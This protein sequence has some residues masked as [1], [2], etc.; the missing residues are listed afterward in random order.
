MPRPFSRVRPTR[1]RPGLDAEADVIRLPG[2]SVRLVQPTTPR[3]D[4]I[5]LDL[6]R[7]RRRLAPGPVASTDRGASLVEYAL[8]VAHRRRVHLASRS[9]AAASIESPRWA[10]RSAR[11]ARSNAA[12]AA[13]RRHPVPRATIAAA[14]HAG[15][16]P[17]TTAGL[18]RHGDVP[19]TSSASRAPLVL[20]QRWLR[21]ARPEHDVDVPVVEHLLQR[22]SAAAPGSR[23]RRRPGTCRS[24]RR[25]TTARPSPMHAARGSCPTCRARDPAVS[26]RAGRCSSSHAT[27]RRDRSRGRT[28]GCDEARR[29]RATAATTTRPPPATTVPGPRRLSPVERAEPVGSPS[30][31]RGPSRCDADRDVAR[32]EQAAAPGT[33]P[34]APPRGRTGDAPARA[35]RTTTCTRKSRA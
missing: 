30:A 20:G 17:V 21:G 15:D 11:D 24:G 10:P 1:R 26:A 6:V 22:A 29:P 2:C 3:A 33:P 16:G 8:L 27:A 12:D 13:R 18:R 32:P 5:M 7:I 31:S 25:R 28:P 23:R 14:G 19:A 9:S 34:A 35:P 4:P